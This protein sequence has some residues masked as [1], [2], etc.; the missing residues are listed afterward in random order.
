MKCTFSIVLMLMLAVTS[1][2][3]KDNTSAARHLTIKNGSVTVNYGQSAK[4]GRAIFASKPNEKA[5]VE[6]GKVWR[7]GDDR[8]TEITF[9]RDCIFA[10]HPLKAGTYTLLIKHLNMEWMLTLNSKL[11]QKGTFMYDKVKDNNVLVAAIGAK[12]LDHVVENFTITLQDNGMLIEWDQMSGF[13][14]IEYAAK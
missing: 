13:A 7:P 9:D 4:N 6:Y 11:G 3:A 14:S 1:G 8:G 5:V 2:N 12:K 10:G